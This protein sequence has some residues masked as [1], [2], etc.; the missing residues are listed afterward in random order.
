LDYSPGKINYN[1]LNLDKGKSLKNQID[2]LK[3]DLLQV[4]YNNKYIIDVGWYPEFDENGKF[5]VY[6]IE[7]F[8]WSSPRI[9]MESK[10]IER[11]ELDLIE[12]IN[13]VKSKINDAEFNGS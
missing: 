8:D 1:D 2:A 4:D 7:D 13:H 5:K 9:I 11:L 10:T 12:C 3:E 6:L